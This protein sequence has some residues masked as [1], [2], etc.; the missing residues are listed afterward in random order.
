MERKR[1][2]I[3]CGNHRFGRKDYE[4]LSSRMDLLIDARL[5]PDTEL[6][7]IWENEQALDELV[8]DD[9]IEQNRQSNCKSAR[10][11]C[12]YAALLSRAGETKKAIAQLK[13][14]AKYAHDENPP[15]PSKSAPP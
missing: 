6:C 9:C 14:A 2:K 8:Y 12:H 5:L 1:R 10:Q 15:G 13:K 11:Y 4:I 7:K 3:R